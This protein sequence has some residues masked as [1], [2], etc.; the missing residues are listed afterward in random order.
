MEKKNNYYH[1]IFYTGDS[2]A[3]FLSSLLWSRPLDWLSQKDWELPNSFPVALK[4]YQIIL[5]VSAW[6]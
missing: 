1:N 5:F 2:D 6:K 4:N 3:K